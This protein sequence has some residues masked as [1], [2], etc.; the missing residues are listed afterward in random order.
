[1]AMPGLHGLY[2]TKQS[3]A[4]HLRIQHTSSKSCTR[5]GKIFTRKSSRRLHVRTCG[6][7]ISKKHA[8]DREPLPCLVCK[9]PFPKV[10]KYNI[11]VRLCKARGLRD[12]RR[13]DIKCHKYQPGNN[14][15]SSPPGTRQTNCQ[16]GD[17]SEETMENKICDKVSPNLQVQGSS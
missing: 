8:L 9:K 3:L 2:P 14:H 13:Q 6:Y 16:G 5:C 12:E 1:M 17:V 11:H 10:A 15:N 4:E 7:G